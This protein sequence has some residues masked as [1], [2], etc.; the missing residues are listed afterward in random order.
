[1][2]AAVIEPTDTVGPS[3]SNTSLDVDVSAN[4]FLFVDVTPNTFSSSVPRPE[5]MSLRSSRMTRSD[6]ESG[7]TRLGRRKSANSSPRDVILPLAC[8][9]SL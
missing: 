9:L 1:M 7:A 2:T 6:V 5:Y 8:F 3:E 4:T